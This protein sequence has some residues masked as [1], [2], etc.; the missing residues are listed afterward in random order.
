MRLAEDLPRTKGGAD[1]ILVLCIH[2]RIKDDRSCSHANARRRAMDLAGAVQNAT[3]RDLDGRRST[4][5]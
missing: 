1:M 5:T 2:D 4:D 3:V